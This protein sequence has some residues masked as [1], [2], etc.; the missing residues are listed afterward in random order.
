MLEH[1]GA[2][3]KR[4]KRAQQFQFADAEGLVGVTAEQPPVRRARRGQTGA[5]VAQA[6]AAVD[7][8]EVGEAGDLVQT[9]TDDG[10]EVVP[11][12][13]APA[14]I[15]RSRHVKTHY[16]PHPSGPCLL[17]FKPPRTWQATCPRTCSHRNPARPNTKCTRTMSYDVHDPD[18]EQQVLRL[19]RCWLSVCMDYGTR[20]QHMA[21]TPADADVPSK[22]T[23]KANALRVLPADY[24][25][26]PDAP[27]A[28]RSSAASPR[29]S[30][31][32]PPPP[33]RCRGKKSAAALSS[34]DPA[35]PGPPA[36][37]CALQSGLKLSSA[38][39]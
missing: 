20:T 29:E 34:V 30:M 1:I 32:M 4:G 3:K 14:R 12:P 18:S 39:V 21:F 5:R 24:Q 15:A 25:S 22:E 35:R 7:S 28:R 36:R 19:L 6:P 11:P 26:D 37:L 31:P 2:V 23:I 33:R 9:E 17:T 38:H 13:P 27:A 10:V 16:W 8:A